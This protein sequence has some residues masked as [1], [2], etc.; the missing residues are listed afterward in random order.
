MQG[1]PLLAHHLHYS[2]HSGSGV[3]L[4][5][6]TA[7]ADANCFQGGGGERIHRQQLGGSEPGGSSWGG[8]GPVNHISKSTSSYK[9]Q[10]LGG[11]SEPAAAAGGRGEILSPPPSWKRCAS[12]LGRGHACSRRGDLGK[13]SKYSSLRGRPRAASIAY[14]DTYRST[15]VQDSQHA[16]TRLWRAVVS[17]TSCHNGGVTAVVKVSTRSTDGETQSGSGDGTVWR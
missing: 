7:G 16:S 8:A 13:P 15:S 3:Q 14:N 1:D 9:W 10:Q 5:A 2:A 11:G 12:A 4:Q 6:L 17:T